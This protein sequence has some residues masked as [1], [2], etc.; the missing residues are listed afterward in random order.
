MVLRDISYGLMAVIAIIGSQLIFVA[1][2]KP[3]VCGDNKRPVINLAITIIIITTVLLSNLF[4]S[5][6]NLQLWAPLFICLL[7]AISLAS[8]IYYLICQFKEI[9]EKGDDLAVVKGADG[10]NHD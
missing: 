3:Y 2:R 9:C 7:L 10:K 6:G 4:P 8:N 5:V 1:Y